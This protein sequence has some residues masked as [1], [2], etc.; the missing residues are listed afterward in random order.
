MVH[1]KT[2]SLTLLPKFNL[3]HLLDK[4][5]FYMMASS[6]KFNFRCTVLY[7]FYCAVSVLCHICVYYAVF[8]VLCCIWLYCAISVCT[9]LYL[10][11]LCH[12]CLY[13]AI[14]FCTMLYVLAFCCIFLCCAKYVCTVP[15]LFKLSHIY[16]CFVSPTIRPFLIQLF[17]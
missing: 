16:L 12:M 7:L 17:H 4:A 15:Y 13:Y 10:V 6:L 14:S 11:A 3:L 9:M 8:F 5:Y 2:K 1:F